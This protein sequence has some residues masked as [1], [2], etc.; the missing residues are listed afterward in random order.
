MPVAPDR[1]F[2][3]GGQSWSWQYVF[4]SGKLLVDPRSG[5][6]RRHQI[7]EKTVQRSVE[8]A[9]QKTGIVKLAASHI[10][11]HSFATHLLEGD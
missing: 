4:P 2:P 8:K 1:K 3:S 5:V 9:V 7:D 10:L 6:I 11:H